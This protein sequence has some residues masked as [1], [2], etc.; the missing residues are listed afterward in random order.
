[1]YVVESLSKGVIASFE[2]EKQ[3]I[4]YANRYCYNEDVWV[5]KVD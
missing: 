5:T 3:A 4:A 2:T 1:M